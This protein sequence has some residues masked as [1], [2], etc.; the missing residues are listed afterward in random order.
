MKVLKGENCMFQILLHD[1]NDLEEF[2]ETASK[3]DSEIN[4]ESGSIFIDA[5]SFLGVLTM[6]IHRKLRV[7]VIGEDAEFVNRVQ[8]FAIG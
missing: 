6:G 1:L 5:K 7:N 3:S 2:V 8:K 4:L